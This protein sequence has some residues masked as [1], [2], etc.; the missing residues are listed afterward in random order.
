MMASIIDTL[1]P[2]LTDEHRSIYHIGMVLA[3]GT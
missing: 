1:G 3:I 2:H